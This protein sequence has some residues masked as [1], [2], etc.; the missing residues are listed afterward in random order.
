MPLPFT[1]PVSIHGQDQVPEGYAKHFCLGSE[2]DC[3]RSSLSC[4]STLSF[5]SCY[6]SPWL[7]LNDLWFVSGGQP[8]LRVLVTRRSE[9]GSRRQQVSLQD[10]EKSRKANIMRKFSE[11]NRSI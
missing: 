7:V 2:I 3:S 9:V 5:A 1:L 4:C 10:K 6:F 11:S 8:D